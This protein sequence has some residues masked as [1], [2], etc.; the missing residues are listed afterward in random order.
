MKNSTMAI[1]AVL[2]ALISISIMPQI[3]AA[4]SKEKLMKSISRKQME[5]EKK[6]VN[7]W[8]AG[9]R[10]T[11]LET[12]L[13]EY[14]ALEVRQRAFAKNKGAN[15]LIVSVSEN[16]NYKPDNPIDLGRQIVLE[17]FKKKGIDIVDKNFVVG[18]YMIKQK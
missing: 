9:E 6:I 12:E 13:S 5:C 14:V 3:E 16:P 11:P 8:M 1:V 4:T 10:G 7:M 15:S 2:I 17:Y 18:T